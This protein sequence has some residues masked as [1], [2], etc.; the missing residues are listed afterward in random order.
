[1]ATFIVDMSDRLCVSRVCVSYVLKYV[2][3]LW[4]VLAVAANDDTIALDRDDLLLG[5]QDD[6]LLARL[7]RDL[8]RQRLR[9]EDDVRVGD[10]RR[11]WRRHLEKELRW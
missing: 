5:W 3:I 4:F 6:V 7:A 8:K 11:W 9:E 10:E 1:M 2:Q